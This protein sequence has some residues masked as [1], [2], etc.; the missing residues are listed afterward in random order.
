MLKGEP[1]GAQQREV[2]LH[3]LGCILDAEEQP[4]GTCFQIANGYIVSALH[5]IEDA[6]QDVMSP[7][8]YRPLRGGAPLLAYVANI[9]EV[10]DLVILRTDA[11]LDS[12]ITLMAM[13][14][15]QQLDMP[16]HIT[17]FATLPEMDGVA[18][19]D[20]QQTT[21]TWEGIAQQTG[22][23]IVLARARADGAVPGMSGCPVLR[24]HDGALVGV[25]TSRYNSSDAWVSGRVW[26]SRTEDLETLLHGIVSIPI[27][28]QPALASRTK[29]LS[30][31][32]LDRNHLLEDP[33]FIKS[34]E[35][36]EPWDDAV[37]A[38][39]QGNIAIVSAPPGVGS[40]TFIQQLA[41]QHTKSDLQIT[42]LHPDEWNEPSIAALPVQ[43]RRAYLLE[44]NHP[45]HDRPSAH[46]VKGLSEIASTYKN[47]ESTLIIAVVDELW[48]GSKAKV[49]DS[50]SV[51]TLNQAP[52]S[53][54]LVEKYLSVR[55]PLLLD[56]V[57]AE[58]IT[59]HLKGLNA[60][61]AAQAVEHILDAREVV[62]DQDADGIRA[63]I[64]EALD[65]HVALL[66]RLFD[67]YEPV[68]AQITRRRRAEALYKIRTEEQRPLALS[69][70]CLL[71]ALSFRDT[72]RI[73]QLEEDSRRLLERLEA[74]KPQP[75]ASVDV[76]TL[77]SGPGIRGRIRR[78]TAEVGP[79]ETVILRRPSLKSAVIHYVWD[80][81]T[82]LRKPLADWLISLIKLDNTR[83]EAIC[84]WISRLIRQ[85]QDVAFMRTYLSDVCVKQER[86]D[87]L[88]R[89]LYDA[90]QD[91]HM[92][93][94]SERLLY[95]W[96]LKP[97]MQ[98]VVID[99]AERLLPTDRGAIALRRLR[100]VADAPRSRPGA[101]ER[102]LNAFQNAASDQSSREWFLSEA[103]PWFVPRSMETSATS[104]KLAF[105]AIMHLEVDGIPW[106]L[107]PESVGVDINRML[108]ETISDLHVS[109]SAGASLVALLRKAALSDELYSRA[110]DRITEAV[111]NHGA[112]QAIFNFSS[113]LA[114][115]GEEISRDVV[116]DVSSRMHARLTLN[117]EST[118]P[119]NPS[120]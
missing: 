11:Y 48:R 75:T 35:W 119:A 84:T 114:K 51:V 37:Q 39:E 52:N 19:Y 32:T 40:T 58:E 54:E 92:Q 116:G 63:Y 47:L 20:Y 102:V 60:L 23:G 21:G 82:E 87:V 107:T 53:Q 89:L 117:S 98:D 96:A 72:V 80:N 18:E 41:A 62:K 67:D 103:R 95:D 65:D 46:F 4:I 31:T 10:H 120:A 66:D 7:I 88:S 57:R 78:T 109:Q 12:S 1:T 113:T 16:I 73:P 110:I 76:G 56:V 25:L 91:P 74:A 90:A 97:E 17:G 106:L 29:W 43:P 49:A 70:R 44:L 94:H 79:G 2:H 61:Q 93:R 59:T 15:V 38:I 36:S 45:D 112:I 118:S 27:E 14:E 71:I 33:C 64:A 100:R 101:K 24:A 81:Y 86:P 26:I 69:D 28:R 13:S 115:T 85:N 8:K 3:F 105:I 108:A 42:L 99:V 111:V 9:D 104:T 5:V 55:A 83:T 6:Y 50:V 22:S 30:S 34:S 77:L 68:Q